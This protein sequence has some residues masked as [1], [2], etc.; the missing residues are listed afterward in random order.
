MNF[1][2][3]IIIFFFFFNFSKAYTEKKYCR[4]INPAD[5]TCDFCE[6]SYWNE[7]L[8]KCTLVEDGLKIAN[9]ISY[10]YISED[11]LACQRCDHGYVFH[12]SKCWKIPS[13]ENCILGSPFGQHCEVCAEGFAHLIV[14]E[15][16]EDLDPLKD[17]GPELKEDDERTAICVKVA[18]GQRRI[19]KGKYNLPSK[20]YKNCRYNG[21]FYCHQC[22]EGYALSGSS[23][24]CV[25]SKISNCLTVSVDQKQCLNCEEGHF[26]T[27]DYKCSRNENFVDP[28]LIA[29]GV[30]HMLIV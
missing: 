21:S 18:K 15:G 4:S 6:A 22:N 5:G 27:T 19:K 25:K 16:V 24:H 1:A 2:L 12:H 10:S 3:L 28:D 7:N 20:W 29:N 8:N 23:Y 30:H 14:K 9:C 13:E 11:F 17:F 26:V